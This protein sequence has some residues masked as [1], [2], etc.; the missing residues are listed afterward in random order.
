[1]IKAIQNKQNPSNKKD[2]EQIKNSSEYNKLFDNDN[3]NLCIQNER[4]FISKNKN[5]KRKF[6]DIIISNE[7]W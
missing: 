3:K 7:S 5:K 6:Y 2:N 1:M 4:K